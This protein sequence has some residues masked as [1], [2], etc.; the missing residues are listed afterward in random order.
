MIINRFRG[1]AAGR[2]RCVEHAGIVYAVATAPGDDIKE[3]TRNTLAQ[4][5]ESLKMAGRTRHA[6][7]KH[8]FFLPTWRKNR[9]WTKSGTTGSGQIGRTGLNGP[10]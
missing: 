8:R 6:F 5:D 2:N 7:Y 10:A 9:P 1:S 3:Q 4:I